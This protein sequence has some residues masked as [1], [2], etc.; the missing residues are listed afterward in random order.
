[1]KTILSFFVLSLL[2]ASVTSGQAVPKTHIIEIFPAQPILQAKIDRQIAGLNDESAVWKV[3]YPQVAKLKSFISIYVYK[4]PGN[5]TE[6]IFNPMKLQPGV[7]GKMVFESKGTSSTL[8][9]SPEG[10]RSLP[11]TIVLLDTLKLKI[12]FNT[13]SFPVSDYYIRWKAPL[14]GPL[15]EVR[16]PV[17]HGQQVSIMYSGSNTLG[18]YHPFELRNTASDNRL[19]LK[20]CLYML[21]PEEK[22]HLKT[23]ADAFINSDATYNHLD[24]VNLLK[25]YLNVRY[26]K[27]LDQQL[28]EWVT[29]NFSVLK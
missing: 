26:G 16:L 24:V 28:N 12:L 7:N 8:I 6:L 10:F 23:L 15:K 14:T 1:M 4:G 29:V 18:A 20:S 3:A 25:H 13:S 2:W 27:A 17:G 11:D 5:H 21:S 9:D 22:K 19:L